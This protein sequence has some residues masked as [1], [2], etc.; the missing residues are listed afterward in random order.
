MK[1]HLVFSLL[2][3]LRSF[4]P[5]PSV[6]GTPLS[7]KRQRGEK[8]VLRALSFHLLGGGFSNLIINIR[9]KTDRKSLIAIT[10]VYP[11]TLFI[12]TVSNFFFFS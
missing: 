7:K 3:P 9:Q 10:K 2:L 5:P 12:C 6:A 8:Q 4:G 1:K 11:T